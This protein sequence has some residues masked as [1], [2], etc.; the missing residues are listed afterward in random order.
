MPRVYNLPAVE[1]VQPGGEVVLYLIHPGTTPG[2]SWLLTSPSGQ[3]YTVLFGPRAWGC[4]CAARRFRP[5][6]CK[7]VRAV[8]E[9]LQAAQA[10][11]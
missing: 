9:M 5:E 6:L 2:R 11:R 8:Q 7:H 1:V 4:S 10:A 3:V